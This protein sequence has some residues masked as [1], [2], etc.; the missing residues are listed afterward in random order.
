M[1]NPITKF[2]SSVIKYITGL[3]IK[4]HCVK[5]T[6]MNVYHYTSLEALIKILRSDCI[7]FHGSRYDSMNDPTDCI[8][9]KD[10]VLPLYRKK[11]KASERPEAE[12]EEIENYPYVVCFSKKKDDFLMWRFYHSEV[13]LIIDKGALFKLQESN[14]I[15][16]VDDVSYT[17]D[18]H[19]KETFQKKI[20]GASPDSD[21]NKAYLY[22]FP[23]IKNNAYENEQEV[24]IIW[25]DF[26]LF[27]AESKGGGEAEIIDQEIPDGI[28]CKEV[29]NGDIRLYKEFKFDKS[30]LKGI[31]L[32]IFD[33]PTFEKTRYHLRLL[34]HQRGYHIKLEDIVQ[35]QAFPFIK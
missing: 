19:L 16:L 30:A 1:F 3:I 24:R 28:D 27:T 23:F 31:I 29:R 13:A 6:S 34:L 20:D 21:M 2:I 15:I 33:K 12:M 8:Y 17:D 26:D 11:L 32:H 25:P 14:K 35:T 5:K 9:A 22:A 18:K 10:K 4:K 7:C